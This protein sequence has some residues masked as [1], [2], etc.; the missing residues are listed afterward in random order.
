MLGGGD[1]NFV[2]GPVWASA[3]SEVDASW[4]QA[5]VPMP[6]NQVHDHSSAADWRRDL[7]NSGHPE[8]LEVDRS[9][10][11]TCTRIGDRVIVGVDPGHGR[12]PNPRWTALV[13]ARAT[14][15]MLP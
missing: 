5:Q 4:L 12:T 8:L 15:V 9:K 7:L 2:A 14:V 6:F 10:S 13:F 3:D 1:P 11:R